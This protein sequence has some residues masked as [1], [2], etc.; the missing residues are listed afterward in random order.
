MVDV[1][2]SGTAGGRI[3]SPFEEGLDRP[4]E[5]EAAPLPLAPLP[6]VV[7]GSA[8]LSLLAEGFSVTEAAVIG[9]GG[10]WPERSTK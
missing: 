2:G 6:R 5:G 4:F 10:V 8:L 7:A 1:V 9:G 3:L